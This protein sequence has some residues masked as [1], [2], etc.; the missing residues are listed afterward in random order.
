ML[1]HAGAPHSTPGICHDGYI[2]P[3]F[4]AFEISSLACD[5][6]T[7]TAP[8]M[9]MHTSR[10]LYGISMVS[11]RIVDTPTNADMRSAAETTADRVTACTAC[12]A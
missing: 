5:T 4:L 1:R 12:V 8:A 11:S 9:T 10:T 7:A 3:S 2:R 6:A